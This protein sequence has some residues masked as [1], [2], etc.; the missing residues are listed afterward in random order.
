MQGLPPPRPVQAGHPRADGQIVLRHGGR[1]N[2]QQVV[3]ACGGMCQGQAVISSCPTHD[4]HPLHVCK[5][6]LLAHQGEARVAGARDGWGG[7]LQHRAHG[8]ESAVHMDAHHVVPLVQ[9]V[10]RI[11]REPFHV[12]QGE[13]VEGRWNQN[14]HVGSQH[15]GARPAED[16]AGG[17]IARN[18]VPEIQLASTQHQH[19]GVVVQGC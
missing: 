14:A 4:G 7:R 19:S 18:D 17:R 10:S 9:E 2:A 5:L 12:R 3:H 6:Q 8:N 13:L 1:V 11:A 15:L 16:A